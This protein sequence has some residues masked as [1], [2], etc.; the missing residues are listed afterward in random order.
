MEL[1]GKSKKELLVWQKIVV[2]DSPE[3]L[4]TTEKELQRFSNEQAA[5]DIRIIQDCNRI[6]GETVVPDVFFSRLDLLKKHSLHL[7]QL[8]PYV[9]FSGASPSE[10]Y[11]QVIDEEQDAIYNFI[12]RSYNRVWDEASKMKT[13]AGKKRKFQNYFN[14]MNTFQECMNDKNIAYLQYK[15]RN[16]V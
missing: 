1:F 8:E 5:N 14:A 13:E 16:L 3:K 12:V 9:N 10:A 4:I 11:R 2:T 15:Q 7:I 6:L